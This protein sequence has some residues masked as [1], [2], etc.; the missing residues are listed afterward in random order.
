MRVAEAKEGPR[1]QHTVPL[2]LFAAPVPALILPL[3]T[4]AHVEKGKTREATLAKKSIKVDD[5]IQMAI[6]IFSKRKTTCKGKM[7]TM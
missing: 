5:G 1:K 7:K 6:T 3:L 2:L 4:Q